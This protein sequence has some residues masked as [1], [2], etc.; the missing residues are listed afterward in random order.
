[1]LKGVPRKRYTG[2][3]KEKTVNG[4]VKFRKFEQ[5]GLQKKGTVI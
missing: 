2:E 4:M 5:N 3:F 1:M